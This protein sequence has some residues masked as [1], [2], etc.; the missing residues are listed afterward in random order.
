MKRK[1]IQEIL[2]ERTVIFYDIESFKKYALFT[3]KNKGSQ[4]VITVDFISGDTV[5]NKKSTEELLYYISEIIKDGVLVGYN[6]K[7]Y[8][9]IIILTIWNNAIGYSG[10]GDN[11]LTPEAINKMSF[12]IIEDKTLNYASI[13]DGFMSYDVYS[14]ANKMPSL[15]IA[16]T[17]YGGD[18]RETPIPFSYLGVFDKKMIES[19]KFYCRHDVEMTE[20]LF[21]SD[22]G[23]KYYQMNIKS[24]QIAYDEIAGKN[25]IVW[26]LFSGASNHYEAVVGALTDY[27][28]R[29]PT[30]LSDYD[31]NYK[32]KYDVLRTFGMMSG[33]IEEKDASTFH[34]IYDFFYSPES[35]RERIQSAGKNLVTLDTVIKNSVKIRY[36]LGGAHGSVDNP[37]YVESKNGYKIVHADFQMMYPSIMIAYDIYPPELPSSLKSI[38]SKFAKYRI[39]YKEKG[40]KTTADAYKPI[41]NSVPGRFKYQFSRLF[42]PSSNFRICALGQC[43]ITI[44][45][46]CVR[47]R[48]IQVDTDGIMTLCKDEDYKWNLNCIQYFSE[49]VG[50]KIKAETFDF[51]A[52]QNIHNYAFGC[53]GKVDGIG[54]FFGGKSEWDPNLM[55]IQGVIQKAIVTGCS[56]ESLVREDIKANGIRNFVFVSKTTAKFHAFKVLDVVSGKTEVIDQRFMLSVAALG[57]KAQALGLLPKKVLKLGEDKEQKISSFPPV[58]ININK[59]NDDVP[60]ECIDISYYVNLILSKMEG[61]SSL[62]NLS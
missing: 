8:D 53:E 5:H 47:G 51:F 11:I 34:E 10:E 2:D 54:G 59:L 9:N 18:I 31:L 3:F 46:M 49:L 30:G 23:K 6:C 15:K 62:L 44:L 14:F 24:C 43:F 50:I 33:K 42:S 39:S 61:I 22:L 16:A 41:L 20:I 38:F 55:G 57:D 48:L 28:Y 36:G 58:V 17:L 52:Q 21:N 60:L 35:E 40:D 25:D 37:L 45:A 4:E 12:S 26:K 32:E 7:K 56:I 19:V 1:T 27:S 29:A 13:P